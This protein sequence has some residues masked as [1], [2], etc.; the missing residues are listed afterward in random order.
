[1]RTVKNGFYDVSRED[2][3]PICGKPDWCSWRIDRHVLIC[4][5]VTDGAA[6]LTKD[7]AAGVYYFDAYGNQVDSYRQAVSADPM[8][9]PARSR[10][11]NGSTATATVERHVVLQQQEPAEA[12]TEQE[13]DFLDLAYRFTLSS[14]CLRPQH[15]RDLLKRGMPV[16]GIIDNGYRSMP[17]TAEEKRRVV[18]TIETVCEEPEGVPGFYEAISQS[19][20]E[21]GW[22]MVSKPGLL[23]PCRD[24]K[25]RVLG[26]QVRLD[27]PGEGA[28]YIW[29]SSAGKRSGTAARARA[30]LGLPPRHKQPK[31][32][33]LGITEG[34]LKADLAAALTGIPWI[35]VPGVNQWKKAL[36]IVGYLAPTQIVVAFDADATSNPFVQRSTQQLIE[37]MLRWIGKRDI[38]LQQA[39]WDM[40]A[41]K[42]I[43]DVLAAGN[44]EA[45]Q[46][47]EHTQL[48]AGRGMPNILPAS[49]PHIGLFEP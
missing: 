36:E 38:I 44:A 27:D 6:K 43:D 35:G 2:P 33:V 10:K 1:M 18:E 3:C 49:T 30:H 41:G 8:V 32:R 39:V 20:G 31:R 7:G 11:T 29:F 40:D 9:S 21:V 24:V 22:W 12:E 16:E 5:R 47:V 4:R 26:M 48:L 34:L 46:L 15:V 13:K 28:K 14:L 25:G 45:I 42:G 19:T 37:G 17:L 23:I